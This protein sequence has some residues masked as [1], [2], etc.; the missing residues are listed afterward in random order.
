[1]AG[2]GAGGGQ[3]G[4]FAA[5]GGS[6][7]GNG[8]GGAAGAAGGGANGGGMGGGGMP[9]MPMSPN[10]GSKDRDRERNT[11]LAEDEE[12]WGTTNV[13][14]NGVIGLAEEREPVQPTHVPAGV[15][16]GRVPEAARRQAESDAAKQAAAAQEGAA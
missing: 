2:G 7:A 5:G 11:W 1:G 10:Q 9:M 15:A 12:I 13:D 14:G 3:D 16:A 6:G 8:A 4:A